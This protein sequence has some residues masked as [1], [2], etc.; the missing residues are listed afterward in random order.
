M[1]IGIITFQRAHSFGAQMQK[2][3]LYTF[4]KNQGHD[5]WIL[6]YH[7]PWV[8]DCYLQEDY[9]TK[10]RKNVSNSKGN[11]IQRIK[12]LIKHF[13]D[14]LNRYE[15]YRDARIKKYNDFIERFQLTKR[16]EN[17][18]DM[19][20]DLD[21]LITGSDQV[22]NSY[23]THGHK[24]PYFLDNG[25]KETKFPTRV[26]Y[27]PSSDK[28]Y[29]DLL[30]DDKFYIQSILNSFDYLSVREKSM[31]EYFNGT[32]NINV[33]VVLDPT[34]LL[35]KDYYLK[36]AITPPIE[37]YVCTYCVS[38]NT[39]PHKLAKKIASERNL[40][41][42]ETQAC[43]I[44]YNKKQAYGPLEV[45]GLLCYADVIVTSSFHGM[46]IAV[47]NRKDFYCAYEK[48]TARV[49]DLLTKFLI[50]DRMLHS[51]ND[52]HGFQPVQYD[53]ETISSE[54]NASKRWLLN[55]LNNTNSKLI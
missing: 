39:L 19:P 2:Y 1:K 25:K 47:I 42:I 13:Y 20:T 41:L 4:L 35:T 50:P 7:C 15:R 22:W 6:D 51:L 48:P 17:P 53:E 21:V 11:V 29:Y 37:H 27:A 16:F 18:E 40:K 43:K 8:E 24:K 5:V 14:K 30:C 46:A 26:S 45:L 32:L 3:A 23:I 49:D 44:A 38:G 9:V 10:N 28:K 33:D 12:M 31:A 54:I 36:V 34:F 52:Y 55:S